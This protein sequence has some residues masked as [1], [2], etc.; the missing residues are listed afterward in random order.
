[1]QRT[2]SEKSKSA[3]RSVGQG[4]LVKFREA[5]CRT[6]GEDE[7]PVE[8]PFERSPVAHARRG[9]RAHLCSAWPRP[10][11]R[12]QAPD[13]PRC[14]RPAQRAGATKDLRYVLWLTRGSSP[15]TI[16]YCVVL[17]QFLGVG[18]VP[19][20]CENWNGPSCGRNEVCGREMTAETYS[21]CEFRR[22]KYSVPRTPELTL[23]GIRL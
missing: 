11:R 20:A 15:D 1:M 3:N 6:V 10:G 21:R 14:A 16:L 7:T 18:R 12:P 22:V 19:L 5:L 13:C 4:E 23:Q 2:V 17:C 9:R 8:P